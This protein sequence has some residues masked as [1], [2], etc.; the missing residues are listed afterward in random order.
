MFSSVVVNRLRKVVTK[1]DV[2]EVDMGLQPYLVLP[3]DGHGT[4]APFNI[5]LAGISYMVF[6]K[7]I[8]WEGLVKRWRQA[9]RRQHMVLLSIMFIKIYFLCNYFLCS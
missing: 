4:T 3:R 2:C 1:Q 5:P 8:P 7:I 9:N 6:D